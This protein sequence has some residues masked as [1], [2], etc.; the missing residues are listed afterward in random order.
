MPSINQPTRI[1]LVAQHLLTDDNV[2][3]SI[4]H[5]LTTQAGTPDPSLILFDQKSTIQKTSYCN[6]KLR[7]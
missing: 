3:L 4:R 7:P 2:S 1:F 5:C 6:W